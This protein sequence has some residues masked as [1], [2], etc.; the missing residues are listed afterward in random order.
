MKKNLIIIDFLLLL[1]K[2]CEI[3]DSIKELIEND[4]KNDYI[5]ISEESILL[6]EPFLKNI[7]VR[8]FFTDS[9]CVYFRNED[10]LYI[11]DHQEKIPD[12]IDNIIINEIFQYFLNLPYKIPKGAIIKGDFY[13]YFSLVGQKYPQNY[14]LYNIFPIELYLEELK[15]KIQ[16]LCFENNLDFEF[17]EISCIGFYLIPKKF[18]KNQIISKLPFDEYNKIFFTGNYNNHNIEI[19]DNSL[20]NDIKIKDIEQLKYFLETL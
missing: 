19:M 5:L 7:K 8:G 12:N 11:L 6:L 17:I 18:K 1:T 2:K 9:G 10:N 20:I 3:D 13:Y 16:I 4:E 15:L 14:F